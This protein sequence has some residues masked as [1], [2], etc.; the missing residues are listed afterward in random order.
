MDWGDDRAVGAAVESSLCADPDIEF[1]VAFGSRLTGTPTTG[2]DLD[3][4]VKFVTTLSASERFDKLCF[5]SG[6]LQ[7]DATPF[8]DISDIE[9]LPVEI[10]HEAVSE[11]RFVC[12]DDQAFDRF[13]R[14][15][16]ADFQEQREERRRSDRKL[17]T[18][19]ATEGLRG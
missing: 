2:S 5:L 8:V 1:V 11:G 10:A 13:S 15:I 14:A 16:E 17:I 4:A 12:G 19:I 9:R 3:I 7:S 18:R 6:D